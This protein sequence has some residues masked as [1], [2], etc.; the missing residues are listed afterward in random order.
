MPKFIYVF[1]EDACDKLI[2][3]GYTLMKA[4]IN[5]H[6]FIFVNNKEQLLFTHDDIKYALSDTLTF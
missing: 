1:N 4:D 2:S 6:T 5:K 3:M